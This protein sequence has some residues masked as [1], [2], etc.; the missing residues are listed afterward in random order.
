VLHSITHEDCTAIDSNDFD[1]VNTLTEYRTA[2][3][4]FAFATVYMNDHVETT[5]TL[6]VR[7]VAHLL[8]H[9]LALQSVVNL[10]LSSLD[11]VAGQLHGDTVHDES[12]SRRTITHALTALRDAWSA[13]ST[14][15]RE[16]GT[17]HVRAVTATVDAVHTAL[18]PHITHMATA[19]HS[20]YATVARHCQAERTTQTSAGRNGV[21]TACETY[22]PYRTGFENLPE[23]LKLSAE[24]TYE[25]LVVTIDGNTTG[26][27][28]AIILSTV[29][30]NGDNVELRTEHVLDVIT[31]EELFTSL[32]LVLGLLLQ[33]T[34][35]SQ[36]GIIESMQRDV[37]TLRANVLS[38]APD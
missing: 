31:S 13:V 15:K 24:L 1:V 7:T 2:V 37:Y 6:G 20:F 28:P 4:K 21:I 14:D 8:A 25:L 17:V 30:A 5:E 18:A 22:K 9:S 23:L 27:G 19:M 3:S 38:N 26:A 12:L 16:P 35:P 29:S 11:A 10:Y 34:H 36:R 32:D 33:L